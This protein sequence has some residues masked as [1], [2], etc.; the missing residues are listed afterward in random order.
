MGG[1]SLT[2]A[3]PGEALRFLRRQLWV[4]GDLHLK[5]GEKGFATARFSKVITR[6]GGGGNSGARFGLEQTVL[7]LAFVS[8]R[9]FTG[10]WGTLGVLPGAVGHSVSVCS[11]LV[12][13]WVTPFVLRSPPIFIGQR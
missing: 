8:G 1:A 4:V 2:V 5:A 10:G 9:H 6:V 13:W 12:G 7:L 11:S 3:S